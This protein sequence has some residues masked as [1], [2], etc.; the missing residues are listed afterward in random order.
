[1]EIDLFVH[2]MTGANLVLGIQWFKT[3]GY[4]LSNYHRIAIEFN[5]R[6]SKVTWVGEPLLADDTFSQKELNYLVVSSVGGFFL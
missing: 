1:M 6:V 4:F 2:N 5:W 3:M